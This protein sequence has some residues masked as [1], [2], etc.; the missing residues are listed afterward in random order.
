MTF[1]LGIKVDEGMVGIAGSGVTA[2]SEAITAKR[3][4]VLSPKLISP[5]ESNVTALLR[6]GLS[7]EGG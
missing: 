6:P 7:I 1:C 5:V 3:I 4:T 2:G